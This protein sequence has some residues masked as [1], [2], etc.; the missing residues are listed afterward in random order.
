MKSPGKRLERLVAAIHYAESEGAKVTWNDIIEGRQ[1]DVTIRF[2]YGLNTYL[3]VI[4]CKDHAS[5]ISVDKVD[6]LVTKARDVKANKAILVSTA[7][8]QSGCN[9]V[10][11]RHGIQLLVLS[12]KEL[13]E[14]PEL[15]AQI[16]PVLNIYNVRFVLTDGSGEIYLEDW[17]GRL[18]YLMS[19]SRVDLSRLVKRPDQLIADWQR[20]NPTL[21]TNRVN[22]VE[23]SLSEEAVLHMPYESAK[24]VRAMRFSCSLIKAAVSEQP[25]LDNH[26][27]AGM[28]THIE[29]RDTEGN[30]H[31][32]TRLSSI[33]LG[34]DT[35]VR[36]GRFYEQSAMYHRYYCKKIDGNKITWILLESYQHGRLIQAEYI[37]DVK[38]AIHYI[39]V[40][41]KVILA[42]LR[43]MLD[44][45]NAYYPKGEEPIL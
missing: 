16:R 30:L 21:D 36:P 3:T 4:E 11:E 5:K 41:D 44:R 17:G 19:E 7:G 14:M 12:E 6:A 42:R 15:V 1:F 37:Q 28:E 10:A 34:F 43:L 8:F 20:T 18:R 9:S 27:L 39:E 38:Y 32:T 24:I 25:M 26:I 13:P 29:L 31:H 35:N 33:P 2:K 23:I 45:M 22:E 40:M